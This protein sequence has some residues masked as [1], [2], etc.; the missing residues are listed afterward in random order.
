MRKTTD[1]AKRFVEMTAEHQGW[2]LNRDDA[3]RGSLVEGLATNYNRYG[4]FLC[5][6]RDTAGSREK[7]KDVICPCVY[8]RDDQKEFG[9]CYCGLYLTK[10]FFAGGKEPRPLPERRPPELIP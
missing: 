10:E 2:K 7:D 6:C 1:D 8:C 3:F 9:H 5:P 4:Y